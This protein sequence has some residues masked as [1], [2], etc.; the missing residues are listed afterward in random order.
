MA[1]ALALIRPGTRVASICTGA[2]ILAAAGLLD[3][4]PATTHWKNSPA[5]EQLFPHVDLNRDVLFTESDGVTSA[6][7]ASGLD[8]RIHM[9][10]S[11]H[12]AVVANDVARG[13]VIPPHREGGQAPYIQRPVPSSEGSVTSRAR[14]WALDHLDEP[15]MVDSLARA[16]A[17]SRRTFTRKFREETGISPLQWLVEQRVQRACELLEGSDRTV[18]RIAADAGFGT[19]AA[20]RLHFRQDAR[21]LSPAVQDDVPRPRCRLGKRAGP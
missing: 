19:S 7:V 16:C 3:G 9:I 21:R 15:I 2:S 17:V 4:R 10:R 18:D 11:D 1:A 13:T 14:A 8:L 12:G 5:F 20:M 6:G